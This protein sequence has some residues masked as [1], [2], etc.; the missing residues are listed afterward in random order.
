MQSLP[1]KQVALKQVLVIS[2]NSNK[3]F[4]PTRAQTSSSNWRLKKRI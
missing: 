4:E 1:Q 2:Q 3:Q